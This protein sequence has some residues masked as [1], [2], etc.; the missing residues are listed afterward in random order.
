MGSSYLFVYGT[1][2]REFANPWACRLRQQASYLGMAKIQGELY[3]IDSYPGLIATP[4]QQT[5]VSGELY[6][7]EQPSLLRVLDQYENCEDSGGEYIRRC[8]PVWFAQELVLSWVYLY[9]RDVK[10]RSLIASGDFTSSLQGS[11]PDL[12]RALL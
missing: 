1:L 9:N 5:W 10:S 2:R 8:C 11:P 7:I 3:R 4:D 12:G 6:R